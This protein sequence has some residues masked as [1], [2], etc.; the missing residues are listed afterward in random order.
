MSIDFEKEARELFAKL[1]GNP[2]T[3]ATQKDIDIIVPRLKK[4][5]NYGVGYKRDRA[6]VSK[7]KYEQKHKRKTPGKI[8]KKKGRK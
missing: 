3:S 5:Y 7:E 4:C 8:Y 2:G 6:F 1:T